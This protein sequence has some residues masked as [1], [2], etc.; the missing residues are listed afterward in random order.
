MPVPD[1]S[2][3]MISVL[4]DDLD[5]I[6]NI[7]FYFTNSEHIEIKQT[8]KSTDGWRYDMSYGSDGPITR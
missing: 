3:F 6:L 7:L 2:I 4:C 1:V 5:G 8:R